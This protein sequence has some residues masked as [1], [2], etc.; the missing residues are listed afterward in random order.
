MRRPTLAVLLAVLCLAA[1]PLS[2]QRFLGTITGTVS[3]ATGAVVPGAEVTVTDASTGLS[4]TVSTDSNGTY[5][6]PQLPLGSYQ[7]TVKKTGFKDYVKTD[8]VLHVADVLR[9]DVA[10]QPGSASET[11][12]VEAQEIQVQTEGGD[13]SGLVN[14]QQ[15]RELPLNGRV[16]A[17]LT[18]LMPGVATAESFSPTNKG[19]VAGVDMSISGSGAT[20]NLWLVDGAGNNDVGSNRTILVYPSVDSIAEFK[21]QRNSYGPEFG[22]ASGAQ[23]NVVTRQGTNTFHGN[24]YYFGRND[25]F[26]AHS[27]FGART[28]EKDKLRHHDYGYTF[29]GPLWKDRIFFFWSQE[30][31]KILRGD[32]RTAFVPTAAEK[33]GD[34]SG[35]AATFAA[36]CGGP[37]P[38]DPTSP[39][40]A[41]GVGT[42]PFAGNQIPAGDLSPAGLLY[43]QLYPDPNTPLSSTCINWIKSVTSPTNWREES[44]RGDAYITKNVNLMVRYT[45]DSWVNGAPSDFSHLWGDDPFPNVDSKWDQPGKQFVAKLTQTIGVSMVN[46]IQFSYAGNRINVTRGED[47]PGLNE[48]IDQA[49]PPIFG[50]GLKTTGDQLAH[51]TFWGGQ[52]YPALWNM[53]P[54]TNLQDL[55]ALRDDFNVV[56]GKHNLK[57]GALFGWNKKNEFIGGASSAEQSE[58]WGSAGVGGWGGGTTGNILADMLYNNMTLGFDEN[59]TQPEAHTRWHDLEFYAGDTWKVHPRLTLDLGLRWSI[60]YEP[61][62]AQNAIATFVPSLF[63][64]ALTSDPC[65]GLLFAESNPCTTAGFLGGTV[66][67]NRAFR[68]TDFN[69]IAPRLGLAWDIMGNGKTVFRAGVGQFFQRERVAPYL[70]VAGNPP[71]NANVNGIRT[72][73]NDPA[74]PST[75]CID[76]STAFGAPSAA[77]NLKARVPN[78]WQ[79]NA[80]IERE[81][82]ANNILEVS[83][84][85]SRGIHLTSSY[86]INQVAPANRLG[87]LHSRVERD[88]N[89]VALGTCT[90]PDPSQFRPFPELGIDANIL[91]FDRSGNSIYHALQTQ[92]RGRWGG[93]MQYQASYTWSKSIDDGLLDSSDGGLSAGSVIDI[94]NPRLNRGPGPLN[95]PHIFN[96]SLIYDTPKLTDQNGF[97][98][99]VFGDWEIATIVILSH[100]GSVSPRTGAVGGLPGGPSGTGYQDNQFLM[101]DLSQPCRASGD[102]E[103]WLNPN[104]YTLANFNLGGIGNASRGSCYGPGQSQTDFAIYKNWTI[105]FWKSRYTSESA[106]IQFRA[107]IFNLFNNVQFRTLDTTYDAASATLDNANPFFATQILSS[108]P[109]AG[110]GVAAATRDPREIQFGLKIIF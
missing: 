13:L 70:P 99:N 67:D 66:T 108:T 38:M 23:I 93:R 30:W 40:D 59:R 3:D 62:D 15:V 50:F 52:G 6:V 86:A 37:V 48:S 2:A 10:L 78:T 32:T 1:L 17:Q 53:A 28:G 73:D 54:W 12:T 27:Y 41:N 83:Y 91:M 31:N 103:Q 71:F 106:Q 64:P 69:T 21:I 100:G 104:A 85:G 61:Y 98:R 74:N 57:F 101:R 107:E 87:Y 29:G 18:Q 79:W 56:M 22:Q 5:T 89:C 55:F 45:Q 49:A 47:I 42:V 44:I 95:R 84:V 7:V 97:V 43:V 102:T 36:G 77:I 72:F 19:L 60:L 92:F 4:R 80:T 81:L 24:V 16:F 90:L 63:D 94:Y 88:Q 46:S 8:V 35:T 9:T 96:A 58:F 39:L 105:P 51:P 68:D 76:C 82:W 110:F 20:N 14:G 65:N 75:A 25:A 11:I 26:D 34:F 109:G 33:Q